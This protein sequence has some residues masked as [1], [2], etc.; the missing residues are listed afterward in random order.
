[1]TSVEIGVGLVFVSTFWMDQ[2]LP[3]D[4]LHLRRLARDKESE[5]H[6]FNDEC[7]AKLS[8]L[9]ADRSSQA[10][11]TIPCAYRMA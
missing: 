9:L 4:L 7:T 11:I 3:P 1:M 2:A 8:A 6:R 5:Y 10:R